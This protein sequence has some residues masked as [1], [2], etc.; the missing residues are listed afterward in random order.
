MPAPDVENL[1]G[2]DWKGPSPYAFIGDHKWALKPDGLT[3]KVLE[4]LAITYDDFMKSLRKTG[5]TE[6]EILQQQKKA[7]KKIL[8]TTLVKFSWA[9]YANDPAIGPSLLANL[10]GEVRNFLSVGGRIGMLR[11]QMRSGTATPR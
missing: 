3:E 6:L 4:D 11:S 5:I 7:A 9:K 8:E 1:L 10:S 2:V